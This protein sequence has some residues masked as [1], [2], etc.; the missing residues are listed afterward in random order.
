M[1]LIKCSE[2][3]KEISDK[4]KTCPNCGAPVQSNDLKQEVSWGKAI[5][6]IVGILFV[7]FG[8]FLTFDGLSKMSNDVSNSKKYD[9][10]TVTIWKN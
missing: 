7:L 8:L 9:T 1:A 5:G 10:Y 3:G 6:I 2:C 4:A